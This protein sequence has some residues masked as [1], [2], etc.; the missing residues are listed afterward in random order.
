MK[1][2]VQRGPI[3]EQHIGKYPQNLTRI[4]N[5]ETDLV[6]CHTDWIGLKAKFV[7]PIFYII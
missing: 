4:C 2:V 6:I 5:N 1:R 7:F 3:R